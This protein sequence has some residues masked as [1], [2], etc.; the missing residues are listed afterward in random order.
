MNLYVVTIVFHL[1]PSAST[2]TLTVRRRAASNGAA[3]SAVSAAFNALSNLRVQD[4]NDTTHIIPWLQVDSI[5]AT[6]I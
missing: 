1:G 6:E 3:I 2:T 5:S 4:P